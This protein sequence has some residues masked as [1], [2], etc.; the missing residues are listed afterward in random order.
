[1]VRSDPQKN[2]LTTAVPSEPDPTRLDLAMV[3]RGLVTS[4]AR[5]RDLILRGLVLVDGVVVDKPAAKTGADRHIALVADAPRWVS[6]GAEKLIAALDHFG[7]DPQ[8]AAALDIGASTGGF[9]QALLARGAA[10]VTAVDVGHGQLHGSVA[11]DPR[12]SVL[13]GRDAR[14]LTAMDLRY[15]PNLIV[16]DVSFISLGLVLRS[17]LALAAPDAHLIA[18]IKP[19]FEVGRGRIGKGGIVTDPAARLSAVRAVWR[20]VRR[21][22]WRVRGVMASPITGQS[23]NQEYLLAAMGPARS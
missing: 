3:E 10:H 9:T 12:V 20:G 21:Q 7:I 5:A 15:P 8:G 17:V 14:S 22:G 13:E 18:L 4:R 11:A 2:L 23:G 16:V 1:M 19:Q 6:R